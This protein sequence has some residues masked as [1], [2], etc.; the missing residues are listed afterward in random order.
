MPRLD[1]QSQDIQDYYTLD[2]DPDMPPLDLCLDC[3]YAW[4]GE[5]RDDVIDHP[6]YEEQ[7]PPY[8][9]F[10]CGAILTEADN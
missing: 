2:G 3:F 4:E 7:T 6:P 5:D 10:D 8:E 1:N 9:C